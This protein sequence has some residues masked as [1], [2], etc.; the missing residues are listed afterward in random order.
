[1]KLSTKIYMV[2]YIVTMIPA[3][4]LGKYVIEGITPTGT[5]F[6]FNFNGLGIAGLVL[7]AV[8]NIFGTI[9]YFRFLKMMIFLF[10]IKRL[11]KILQF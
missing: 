10:K 9:L 6:S 7:I 5:G 4:V 3:I 1:M 2:L 11:A 8:S